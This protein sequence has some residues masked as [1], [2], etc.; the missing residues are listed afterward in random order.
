[1]LW[2]LSNC[3]VTQ[4]HDQGAVVGFV[5][6]RSSGDGVKDL[7]RGKVEGKDDSGPKH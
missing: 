7:N 5:Y 2:V 1:M 6:R 4:E 3:R